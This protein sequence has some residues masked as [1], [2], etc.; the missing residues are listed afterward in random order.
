MDSSAGQSTRQQ[1]I[2]IFGHVDV[3]PDARDGLVASVAELQRSTRDDEPG[4]LGYVIAADPAD[5][6]RIQIAE[7]W[8]SADALE[9]HFQHPNFAAT[10]AALRSVNRRGGSSR[11][12]RVDADDEVRGP[13]GQASATFRSAAG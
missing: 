3:E 13:D 8:E 11:K 6:G 7:L 5:P 12:Y 2:A 1:K 9:A 10:G 4:C